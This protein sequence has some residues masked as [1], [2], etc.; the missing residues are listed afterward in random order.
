MVAMGMRL[1]DNCQL[2][3][4][5]TTCERLNR[6]SFFITINPLRMTGVTGGPVNPV[7]VF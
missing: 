2:E 1:V 4:L 5:A 7:A 3:D 6:W